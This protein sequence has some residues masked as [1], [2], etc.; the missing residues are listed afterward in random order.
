MAYDRHIITTDSNLIRPC[1]SL[2][3]DLARPR[4]YKTFFLLSSAE[5][6]F[7][8]LINIQMP[9]LVFIFISTENFTLI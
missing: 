8:V 5:H 2:V 1:V 3:M 6:E 9:T 4:G 7:S